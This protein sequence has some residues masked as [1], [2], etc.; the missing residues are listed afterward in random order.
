MRDDRD[1]WIADGMFHIV[2]PAKAGIHLFST[3]HGL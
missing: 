2:I 1:G 3:A